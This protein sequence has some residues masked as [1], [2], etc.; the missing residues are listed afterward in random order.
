MLYNPAEVGIDRSAFPQEDWSYSIY[1]D[2][3]MKK[4]LALN[5]PISI[6]KV[7]TMRVYVDVDS[8]HAGA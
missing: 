5:I 1:G 2:E 3:D 7:F 8:D 4:E 6:G